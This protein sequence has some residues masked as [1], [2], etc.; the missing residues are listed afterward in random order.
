M[1]DKHHTLFRITV[2]AWLRLQLSVSLST[3]IPF[4]SICPS[5]TFFFLLCLQPSRRPSLPPTLSLDCFSS[6][7][8]HH[9]P[10]QHFASQ[11]SLCPGNPN[12]SYTYTSPHLPT[13]MSSSLIFPYHFSTFPNHQPQSRPPQNKLY[14][15]CSLSLRP[16]SLNPQSKIHANLP[17]QSQANFCSP[18]LI[19]SE[20]LS[21]GSCPGK[22]NPQSNGHLL[23]S[24]Q[25]NPNSSHSSRRHFP[26]LFSQ[27]T[28][29]L[30][31]LAYS[32]SDVCPHTL[33]NIELKSNSNLEA[34]LLPSFHPGCQTNPSTELMPGSALQ[35]QCGRPP[36]APT[37]F[38]HSERVHPVPSA[39][40]LFASLPHPPSQKP[41]LPVATRVPFPNCCSLSPNRPLKAGGV[42]LH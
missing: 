41:S 3:A 27:S 31:S 30:D 1:F 6:S 23:C 15:G 26:Q 24:S 29:Y 32:M 39:C 33:K 34:L 25:L 21:N 2:T 37:A 12:T 10:N 5:S 42:E 8:P 19:N 22:T 35:L 9:H 4:I 20:S 7:S 18:P 28:S 38:P 17:L 13:P 11:L 16:N 36:L 14:Y 40:T